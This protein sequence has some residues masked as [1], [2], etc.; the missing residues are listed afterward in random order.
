MVD[1]ILDA[2][3]VVL[4]EDGYQRAS[5]NRIAREAGV[6][7]GSL[8]RYFADKDAIVSGLSTRLVE[9]FAAEL[10]P[11][12]RTAIALPRE[13]AGRALVSAVLDALDRHAPLLRAIVDRVPADEQAV[14]LRDVQQRITD[15]T[16]HLVVLHG[17]S[18]DSER[19]E[20]TTWMITQMSQHLAVRYVL[21][22]PGFSRELFVEGLERMVDG[23]MASGRPAAGD[24]PA[25]P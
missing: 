17:G 21:D 10:G 12:L 23:L 2:A 14:T 18:R 24:Q 13:E 19:I 1:R 15:V 6:S 20:Q 7:P 3:A 9:D 11:V 5:T 8:Y 25:P 22:A 4:A 16:Y